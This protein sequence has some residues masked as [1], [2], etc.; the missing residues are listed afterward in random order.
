M[1]HLTIVSILLVIG[2][3]VYSQDLINSRHTSYYTYIYQLTDREAKQVRHKDLWEVD[4]SYFHTLVDSFPTNAEYT[5]ELSEGHYLKVHTEENKL[6]FHIT[7][8][9][10]FGVLLATNNTDLTIRVYDLQGDVI[11]DA[12]I[13]VRWKRVRFDKETN[14][15]IDRRSNQR[16]LLEVTVDGFTAWY[17]LDRMYNSSLALRAARTVLYETPVKIVWRPVNFVIHFPIDIGRSIYRGYPRGTV[18]QTGWF[19]RRVGRKI[20]SIFDPYSRSRNFES[21]HK[22]YMVFSK[23][24]Y[25]PGDTVKLKAFVVEE[26]GKPVDD[27]AHLVMHTPRG[28][29]HIATL[30]PYREGGYQTQ[31]VLE[32]SLEL[33]L[34]RNYRIWLEKRDRMRYI[35]GSFRFEDYEL[36]SLRL[37]L[38]ADADR[39]FRGQDLVIRASGKDDNDLNLLDGRLEVLVKTESVNAVFKSGAYL[40]DTLLY[41]EMVLDNEGDTE[42]VIPDSVFPQM[43]LSYSVEVKLLTSDNELLSEKKRIDFYH[44]AFEIEDEIGGDSLEV[45]ARMNGRDTTVLATVYGVDNFG[46]NTE[47]FNDSLPLKLP[48]NPYYRSYSVTSGNL[49]KTIDLRDAPSMVS[50]YSDRDC[51][52]IRIQVQNPRNLPF[53]Y[54][55][56]RRNAEKDRGYSDSLSLEMKTF[57]KQNYYLSIQYLWAGQLMDEHYKISL[58][59]DI[60]HVSVSEPAKIFPSQEVEI[61]VSVTDVNG[62]PVEGVDLTA[63]GMTG[64]FDYRSPG[65]PG[66]EKQRKSKKMINSFSFGGNGNESFPGKKLDFDK[67]NKKAGLDSIAYYRFLYPGN[68]IYR[69]EYRADN[70]ITQF[71]PFVVSEG[72]IIPVHV[73][74]V[75]YKPVYFSWSTNTMP[76]SFQVAPGFHD[77]KIRTSEATF[78]IENVYFQAGMKTILG[79][80]DQ[81]NDPR[82][83]RQSMDNKLSDYE[84]KILYRY[85]FPYRNTFGEKPAY[86]EQNG[87]FQLLTSQ[88]RRIQNYAGPVFSSD[89]NFEIPDGYS[90]DFIHEPF[91]EYEFSKRLLKMRS[92]DSKYFPEHLWRFHAQED[93]LDEV[94]TKRVIEQMWDDILDKRRRASARYTC[95]TTTTP[96]RGRLVVDL[97]D[98]LPGKPVNT[99]LFSNDEQDFTRIYP[100]TANRFEDLEEGV[101]SALYFLPGSGYVKYDSLHSRINGST[102]YQFKGPVEIQNDSF[103][104]FVDDL[105]RD[106]ISGPVSPTFTELYEKPVIL[107]KYRTE[108]IAPGTGKWIEGFV[109]DSEGNPLPGVTVLEI[110]TDNG[111]V[112]DY[113]GNYSLRVTNNH[114]ELQFSFIGFENSEVFVGNQQRIDM[115]LEE[116]VLALDEVVVI[117]YG[118]S[119]K[120]SLTGSVVAMETGAVPFH[121]IDAGVMSALQGK[122]SGLQVEYMSGAPGAIPEIRIRGMGAVDFDA[123]PLI[124]IDGM[125]YAGDLSDLDPGLVRNM[126]ILKGAEATAIYGAQA[127]NGVLLINSGGQSSLTLASDSI[128]T[129]ADNVFSMDGFP[130]S[131]I[132]ENFSDEAFWEPALRTDQDGKATFSVTFPDDITSW[133]T[134]YLAMN[135][136]KQ[137]GK[138]SGE[139]KSYKPL[140][141][142]LAMPRFLVEGDIANVIGKVQNYTPVPQEVQTTFQVSGNVLLDTARRCERVLVDTLPVTG[143]GTDSME[144]SFVIETPF[145][146]RDGEKRQLPV[147]PVGL[148]ETEGSFHVLENDTVIDIVAKPGGET[149]LHARADVLDVMD[150]EISKLINY[151]YSCN[152]QLAS[153]LKALLAEQ[154]ISEFRGEKF[155]QKNRVNRMIRLLDRNRKENGLWGWWKNSRQPSMWISLHVLEALVKAEQM[156]YRVE[157]EAGKIIDWVVWELERGISNERKIWMLK[158][159][160]LAGADLDYNFYVEGLKPEDPEKINCF[161]RYLELRQLCGLETKVDTLEAFRKETMFGNVYYTGKHPGHYLLA[162]DVQNT[163]TAYRILKADGAN[164]HAALL[165]MIRNYLFEMRSGDRWMNTYEAASIIETILPDLVGEDQSIGMPELWINGA[166]EKQVTAFP[167]DTTLHEGDSIRIRKQGDFPVYLTSY[168]RYWNPEP[169]TRRTN[170]EI[171][172]HFEGR[173]DKVLEAGKK[174]RLV[175]DVK[176]KK[177]ADY[178]MINVPIPAGCSYGDKTISTFYEVHREHF[179]HETA[180]FCEQLQEGDYRFE[181]E[182]Q[183]RYNGKYTLNPA[184]IEMMYFPVFNANNGLKKVE[185]D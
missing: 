10:N 165:S 64:K 169:E 30:Q 15:Y 54:F 23:P 71:A 124:V 178:V 96:G 32:D 9:T 105:I 82:V 78:Y 68:R 98:S 108:F 120:L 80:D 119:K 157:I 34:D 36:S 45:F 75:D 44:Q 22:G 111:T 11:K 91:F 84:K 121:G 174:V 76:Y 41:K 40:P 18:A 114:A 65:M 164:E 158:M 167:F 132:R 160:R 77:L 117:G 100:G 162:G 110:G 127:A 89:I 163:L 70:G 97:P 135:G 16:G 49:Q 104:I 155:D 140:M 129:I 43:N 86:I 83:L 149:V 25:R 126:Q 172:T 142:R 39:Q 72:E 38:T 154:L 102:Y 118:T 144:L 37:E 19:F 74:Y 176:V 183:P 182:L 14:S 27:P 56:Y 101:Y 146:Y 185:I 92:Q 88:G 59:E 134:H 67:W 2:S 26:N 73:I 50:C 161:F 130:P 20:S 31:F 28:N 52:S 35:T 179:R 175:V 48:L 87:R 66:F 63:Y 106:H 181:I 95:P 123:A 4:P 125:I 177:Y 150:E 51:D 79:L 61:E 13:T 103:G 166:L 148:E 138:T 136:D 29:V 145:G 62:E 122:V 156:G 47:L 141:A 57:S 128:A 81:T 159:M 173:E 58:R 184:K 99:L 24:I 93:L 53:S 6:K 133:S 17:D 1:K 116:S 85:I 115:I 21:I 46:N 147:F 152:E 113:D 151:R 170:F 137:A 153:K 12:R 107:K 60:L 42:I 5:K 3:V 180:I 143:F 168:R 90:M 109:S 94:L 131:D 8:V 55:I 7:T 171:E 69:Y 112:T 33:I 139:I